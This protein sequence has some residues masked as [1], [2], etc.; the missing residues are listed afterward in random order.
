[1]FQS[2][3]STLLPRVLPALLCSVLLLSSCSSSKPSSTA[4]SG[5]TS[6]AKSY[7]HAVELI[8][9]KQYDP[10]IMTL[11]SLMFSTRATDLED[12]VLFTLANAYFQSEQYMLSADIYRRLLQQT[13]DSPYARRAQFQLARSFEQLSPF[14]ELDQDYTVKAINEF[15]I[16]LDQYQ[17]DGSEKV[18]RDAEMY[19]ELM[20]VNPSNASYKSKYEAAMAE[21]S[22]GSPASYCKTAIPVLREKLAHNRYSIAR[23]YVKLRKY[24]SAEIF[25]DEI[26]R[27]YP[28]TKWNDPSWAGKIDMQIERGKWFEARQSIER[29]QQ[30]FPDKGALVEVSSKKVMENFSESRQNGK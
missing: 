30:Q 17:E 8:A 25:F 14:Y 11:E 16:Y 19:R 23:Q 2:L 15:T 22:K 20:K 3:M 12:D 4:E 21:L 24:K 10:A 27:Q 7:R 26:I 29:F 28:D 9:Q 1:M 6:A 18:A 13:S 5:E